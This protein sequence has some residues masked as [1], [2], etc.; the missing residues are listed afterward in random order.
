MGVQQGADVRRQPYK[1]VSL[2]LGTGD[3]TVV[4]A[5]ARLQTGTP[6]AGRPNFFLS[7]WNFLNAVTVYKFHVDWNSISLSAAPTTACLT[8]T[9]QADFLLGVFTNVDVNTS[10]GDV[11]LLNAP[12]VDQQNTAGT[13]TGTGFGTPNWTGQTFIP[14][15]TGSLVKVDVPLF[16][17]NGANPC[18]GPAGNLTL[19][20]RNTSAGLPTGADLASATIPGFTS[21]AGATFTATFGA[22]PVLTSGTQYAL[23]LRPVTNPAAGSYAWIRSSPSTYANGSRVTS[24]NSG[25]TWTADT[26]RD[27]NFKAYMQTGYNA[28]GNLVSGTKDANPA[29]G[30]TPIWS[31][32]SWNATTPASTS[33]KFQLAGSNSVNGP[34]NFVGPDGTAATF[35][36]TSPASLGQFYGL[37]YL[38]YKAFLSTTDSAVTPTLDDAT[39]CFA[40]V[41]CSGTTPTITPNPAQV[42]ANSTGNTA[43]GPDGMTAY[44]WAITNGTI[45]SSMNA[46]SVTYTAGASGD[47]TLTLIVTTPS[48]CI[49]PNSLMV[50]INPIPG[51]LTITPDGP[52][53]FCTG[54][55]V[56]LTS[57][58]ASGNQWYLN[59]NPIGGATNQAYIA[60]AS[61]DYTVTD[62]STGCTSVPSTATTVTVNP[63]PATPTITPGGP[64]TFCEGGSVT[65]TSSSASG[66]QWY[67]NGNPIGG[68]T[69][70][71]YIA[72]AS[73]DY[74]VTDTASGCTSAHSTATTVTVN[75]TPATPTITPGGPTTFFVGGSVTLTSSGVSGNQWYLNGNPIGGATNQ[76]YIATATGDYTVTVTSSGCTSTP[77]AAATVTVN[78]FVALPPTISKLFLPDT[79]APNGTTLLSFTISKPSSDQDV[80]VTLTG[81]E[82]TDNLPAGLL[83][84]S[85]N[86]LSNDC[87][88]TVTATPGSSSISLSGGT[89][90]PASPD[91]L[92]AGLSL[93]AFYLSSKTQA[94]ASPAQGTCFISVKVKAPGALGTLN[95][96]TGPIASNESGPGAT[97][98]TANLTVTAPPLPPTIAKGF[99]AASIPLSGITSLTFTFTNPNSNVMLMNVSASD[100]MPTGLVVANPN[101]LTGSCEADIGANPGSNTIGITALNLP[102]SSSCSFSVNVT[103]TSAGTKNNIS[104]NVTASYDDGTGNFVPISGGAATAAIDVLKGNQTITFDALTN[105]TFGDA[106]F[107]VSAT[108][109]SG[110]SVSLTA[111]G[112]CTVTSPSPGTVHLTSAG[113]CTITASQG[114]DGNYNAATNV[115]QSFN[116]AQATTTTALSSSINPSDIGQNVTF[117]ATITPPTNASTPTGTVQFKDGADN[118]GSAFN[119]IAGA[120]NTCTAQVSTSTLTTGAHAISAVYSGDTSFIGSSGSLS[121]GQIVTSQPALL[122]I[123]DESGPDPN[124]AAALDSLLLLRDPF[125]V[126]S[127]AA[128]LT[129]G[130]DRNTRVMVFVAN[131]QLNPGEA[132]SAVVVNLIDSSNQSYDV[133]AEDLRLD[134][135]TGFAQV[136]FRLPDTLFPGACTVRVKAHDHISTSAIIRIGP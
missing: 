86:E 89:L 46:Q 20:V 56:T 34:F 5:N 32:F 57:S 97:S 107:S 121:G 12:T 42:C 73:G 14:A 65:L 3:F 78:R 79:V 44:S 43:S 63:T 71:A 99:G 82:F 70:Q 75:P 36:T 130:P 77:S 35:F 4:P 74:T 13:T 55:S 58:S 61:G 112:N 22:P 76:S 26:T 84:A 98:N 2:N 15:V 9:T 136:T 122:L 120:G 10:P 116:I 91:A 1:V 24:T 133:A 16:C 128:W 39:I 129:F 23:I 109:P 7:T 135:T 110:L 29:P 25:G 33:L 19:S 28:S 11:I 40:D 123:L 41:D 17:A 66:N 67:L 101:G 93:L 94:S 21:N 95:N 108:T 87:G 104:D 50:A 54:G 125:P 124:Q 88:G 48:G 114:G 119:C 52:T 31:T 59:G 126:H 103:G 38:Q 49:T 92:R 132:A 127:F 68:A 45:T 53:T 18:T 113:S 62:T 105:K 90:A 117:T 72:T 115:A 47:V 6:P 131:L 80:D 102:A 30:L 27:F 118:L 100:A 8:D 69:N 106:D 60:T 37:R 64:T 96:T 111:A 51:A 83:I 134:P 85:P 81:I